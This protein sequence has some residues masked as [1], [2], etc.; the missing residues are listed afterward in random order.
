[1]SK[2]RAY[3]IAV[4]ILAMAFAPLIIPV[5]RIGTSSSGPVYAAAA[6]APADKDN[7]DDDDDD[8]NDDNNDDDDDDNNDDD[9]DNSDD[10]DDDNVDHGDDNDNDSDMPPPP[11]A[12]PPAP[13]APACSTPGQDITFQSDDGRVTVK[14]F[15]S[16]GQSIK[17]SIR[18][19]IDPASVPPAPGAIVGG[20]LFQLIAEGCD[21]GPIPVL[22]AEINIGVHYT[23]DE[24]AG[25]NEANFKLARLDTTANQWRDTA[26]QVTDPPSNFTSATITEMGFYV[27]YQRP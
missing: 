17:L 16:M 4:T 2:L 19:P 14:V 3:L 7:S 22:P 9:D 24:A 18:R 1:M 5:F 26:K 12:A 20:L 10:D 6:S 11:P 21:G 13:P 27:L 8:N 25:K 15:A 23:D